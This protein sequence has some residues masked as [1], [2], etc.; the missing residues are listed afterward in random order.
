[1]SSTNRGGNVV[2]PDYYVTPIEPIRTFLR[3]LVKLE[4]HV[5][6]GRV[7]DS[8]AGGDQVRPMSYPE[9]LKSLG[10]KDSQITTVDMRS[11]SR[12]QVKS[13]YLKW[14]PEKEFDLVIS[15]PPFCLAREFIEKG[16]KDCVDRGFVIMLL[17][18]NFFGSQ[19]RQ[20]FWQ[21][22]MPKYSFVHSNRM[23]FTPDGKTDSIEYMHCVWENGYYPDYTMTRVI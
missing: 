22:N 11:D 9:A 18:L 6:T 14:V 13:D 1:M 17:R 3:E 21:G 8:A 10:V 2:S 16:W 5:L 15:N 4:P 7:L 19:K 23:S 12:A 20:S